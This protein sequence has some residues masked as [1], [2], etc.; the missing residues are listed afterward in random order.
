MYD[1]SLVTNEL[2]PSDV[3]SSAIRVIGID[4]GTTNSAAAEIVVKPNQTTIEVNSL[5]IEQETPSGTFYN[6]LIPSMVALHQGK[7]FVGEGARQIRSLIGTNKLEQYK[8]IFWDTKN[9]MG[10]RRTFQRAPVHFRS[11]KEISAHVLRKILTTAELQGELPIVS[12]VV[13]VPAS[14]QSSQRLDT[15][16]AVKI[17]GISLSDESL[18]D[19]PVAAFISYMWR[20][21]HSEIV[22]LMHPRNL[23]VFDFGGG[24][25]DVA[26][27]RLQRIESQLSAA[28]L[29]VSRYHRLGG[30]DI[31]RAIALEV[32]TTE[33][34]QQN[35]LD[36]LDIDYKEKSEL[37][38]PTLL[39]LAE[40]LK[41]G[42]CKQVSNLQKFDRFE[43]AAATLHQSSPKS[44]EIHLHSGEALVLKS[45]K[46][47]L[48]QFES[49]LK[50]FLD[51][52]LLHPQESEYVTTCSIF[53]PLT[54][55]LDRVGFEPRD[56]D[57][58]LAVGGSCLIP[59]VQ[60][61]LDDFFENAE[62]LRFNDAASLQTCTAHGAALQ[63]LSLALRGR[64]IVQPTNSDSI[65]IRTSGGIIKLVPANS[66]LPYPAGE[67]WASI[68]S[69]KV[70]RNAITEDVDLRLELVNSSDAIVMSKIWTISPVVSKGNPLVLKYRMDSNH[71]L[72]VRLF[73]KEDP[74]RE[75]AHM[76]ENPF[77]NVVNPNRTRER[78]LELEEQM[79]TET[80]DWEQKFNVVSE[81]A[82]L[83][84]ELGN[85]EKALAL[86]IRLNRNKPNS[87][88]LH[89]M[90]LI[91]GELKDLE[92]ESKFYRAASKLNPNYGGSL[93]NLALSY[94][95]SGDYVN[96][97][98][99]IEQSTRRDSN[100]AYLVLKAL[101]IQE[102]PS[103]SNQQSYLTPLD[104]A[105]T[106][107]SSLSK[108]SDF[109][110]FWYR[111]AARMSKD[112]EL[113]QNIEQ[114]LKSRRKEGA[115]DPAIE[116][117]LPEGPSDLIEKQN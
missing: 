67:E 103:H 100:P 4:L 13:T 92:R 91:S 94:R 14:F 80:L 36:E 113:V 84:R 52:E 101:I 60:K 68:D 39:E 31:D 112:E 41:I 34:L 24:T 55:V 70:P 54:D 9:L 90:G 107:F 10:V 16:E 111:T 2:R 63:S 99:C 96:A 33:L 48:N 51:R 89:Q 104:R 8:D 50:P 69:L 97:L 18:L 72:H 86:L 28:P 109:Q 5:D 11:A 53:A 75:F 40:S 1:L 110:L 114:R 58:C 76:V 44:C 49:V 42:L 27:F 46:L 25:C 47:T 116:G 59:Q 64:G 61:A 117:L 30:G 82:R 29:A 108:L 62:T 87:R 35:D 57:Y 45:P 74:T 21:A 43:S 26:L 66:S 19:E 95:R 12:A 22:K 83:E 79:R 93:F 6:E 56:V 88:V 105:I 81:I 65:S 7:V 20:Q 73:L 115:S 32:L 98:E 77:T 23:I 37:I 15:R 85:N 78:I 71:K 106:Q 17:A 102:S 38:I 3:S